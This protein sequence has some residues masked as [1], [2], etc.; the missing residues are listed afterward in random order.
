MRSVRAWL[1]LAALTASTGGLFGSSFWQAL[2]RVESWGE[3]IP[4]L[5]S[6]PAATGGT[7]ATGM[8]TPISIFFFPSGTE[9]VVT[10][11]ATSG[12]NIFKLSVTGASAASGTAS[13]VAISTTAALTD[14]S[15]G[16]ALSVSGDILYAIVSPTGPTGS[17][18]TLGGNIDFVYTGY[19]G[20]GGV[21]GTFGT[22]AA[23]V[24]WSL[25]TAGGLPT[26]IAV[27]PS[28]TAAYITTSSATAYVM[29]T[30]A[31]GSMATSWALGPTSTQGIFPI[32][33]P[34]GSELYISDLYSK[35]MIYTSLTS[36]SYATGTLSGFTSVT[37]FAGGASSL[38]GICMAPNGQYVYGVFSSLSGG[39][40]AYRVVQ[41]QTYTSGAN[42]HAYTIGW[43]IPVNLNYPGCP[44]I[45]PDGQYVII[46][47]EMTSGS[48]AS[49][50]SLIAIMGVTSASSTYQLVYL[51]ADEDVERLSGGGLLRAPGPVSLFT[52]TAYG[53]TI[54]FDASLAL[55][56]SGEIESYEWDFGDGQTATTTFPV[57]SHEY[58]ERGPFTV[59]LK[60]TN[61]FGESSSVSYA[62]QVVY[63][64]PEGA[65]EQEG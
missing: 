11:G 44:T 45:T 30:S 16:Q 54:L 41:A 23:T 13:K 9:A 8:G 61:A 59:S 24:P 10:N 40:T 46:P 36:G 31:S 39:S 27:A 18:G 14:F 64:H 38:G 22:T 12:A 55:Q 4:I 25:C 1:L 50:G 6:T 33:K 57:T 63:S 62:G 34:D 19:T 48:G 65:D 52:T 2:A 21:A 51:T 37:G 60:V 47:N 7:A 3:V 56:V 43:P 20:A 49:P 29:N 28:G 35:N 32:I 5:L 17:T 42:P 58:S 26:Y 53:P 15:I